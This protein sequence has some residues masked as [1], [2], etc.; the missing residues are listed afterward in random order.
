MRY[1]T[2]KE[3][4][5]ALTVSENTIRRRINEGLI[6]YHDIGVPGRPRIRIT[7]ED[8]HAYVTGTAVKKAS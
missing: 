7:E 5:A 2:T 8:L 6:K 4:A 3:A 1:L